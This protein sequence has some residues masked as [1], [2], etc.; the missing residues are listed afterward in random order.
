MPMTIDISFPTCLGREGLESR[1]RRKS[2]AS[3]LT[4]DTILPMLVLLAPPYPAVILK[5]S[6]WYKLKCMKFLK[7][8]YV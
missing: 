2:V 4:V 7:K 5:K 8:M 3:L 6:K 1:R